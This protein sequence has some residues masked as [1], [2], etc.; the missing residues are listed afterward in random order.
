MMGLHHEAAQRFT[1]RS[2]R[3]IVQ[4]A[5]DRNVDMESCPPRCLDERRERK[6]V[7]YVL[8]PKGDIAGLEERL[9][10]ELRFGTLG[11]LPRVDVGIEVED[12]EV[13]IV[14]ERFV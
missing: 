11:F 10:V 5:E 8:E 1:R 13:G 4:L 6:R 3:V 9:P 7:Q 2:D 14:E 12:D